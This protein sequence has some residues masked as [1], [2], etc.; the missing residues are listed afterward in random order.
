MGVIGSPAFRRAARAAASAVGRDRPFGRLLRLAGERLANPT[1]ALAAV[2]DDA[3]ALVRMVRDVIAGRYRK[4]PRRTLIAVVA[5]LI[6]LIDPIDLIPDFIPAIGLLDDA[7]VLAWVVRQVRRDLDAYLAWEREW[8]GAID[9]EAV[10]TSP[11]APAAL[12]SDT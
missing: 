6:Y 9:V 11:D 3:L 7:A 2:R 10:A 12:P 4:L 5:G 8:G 1:T